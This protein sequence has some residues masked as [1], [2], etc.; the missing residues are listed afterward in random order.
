M[1]ILSLL[2]HQVM[3]AHTA[4]LFHRFRIYRRR[5]VARILIEIRDLG[6][7]GD[8]KGLSGKAAREGEGESCPLP[9]LALSVDFSPVADDNLVSDGQ[10]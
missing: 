3:N 2:Y 5:G 7:Q 4:D 9:R 6:N 10:P 1:S 8:V